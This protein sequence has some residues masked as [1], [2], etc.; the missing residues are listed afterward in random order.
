MKKNF[1]AIK[2]PT[3]DATPFHDFQIS[4]LF[5][6]RLLETYLAE[7]QPGGSRS[8]VSDDNSVRVGSR[9]KGRKTASDDERA[10]AEATEGGD[11]VGI[12]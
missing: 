10:G 11:A 7:L 2:G 3:N 9:F 4:T 1:P 12:R 8:R 6:I 5:W